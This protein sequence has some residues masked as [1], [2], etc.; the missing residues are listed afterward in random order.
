[1]MGDPITKIVLT[2]SSY[3]AWRMT[4]YS[5]EDTFINFIYPGIKEKRCL[6]SVQTYAC[7][8]DD[9]LGIGSR[10]DL[11]RIPKV[12]ESMGY[13]ISW[14]KYNINK[15]FVSYCQLYGMLPGNALTDER[16]RQGGRFAGL[17][18][19]IHIDT[20]K[21]R[22]CTQFQ[23]MG[24]SENFDKPD[25]LVGKARMLYNDV[26]YMKDTLEL[27]ACCAYDND[28]LQ[29]FFNKLRFFIMEQTNYVRLLMPSWMEWKVFKDP[30]A[31]MPPHFGGL[32]LT[33]PGGLEIRCHAPA[34]ELARKFCFNKENPSWSETVMDWSRGVTVTNVVVNK[35]IADSELR[36]R[37]EAEVLD[38]AG[39]IL[40]RRSFETRDAA[41]IGNRAKWNY[42][43][44]EYT[45]LS[46]EVTLVTSKDN[47]YVTLAIHADKP[48][49][50]RKMRSRQV[51]GSIRKILKNVEVPEDY[52][53]EWKKPKSNARFIKTSILTDAF[54]TNFV[55]P[56]LN[57]SRSMF[58][59]NSRSGPTF[60]QNVEEVR[61]K[62]ELGSF[63]IDLDESRDLSH[64]SSLS[65]AEED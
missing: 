21:L 11:M 54:D 47:V 30:V 17:S 49:V 43:G 19:M 24:G 16:T 59:K 50:V 6:T 4:R 9:H 45:D 18:R 13:E 56:S 15:K 14:D 27:A 55:R 40:S 41:S 28:E 58:Y 20:P 42:I 37:T 22:C 34:F 48:Q 33:V 60:V 35:L 7:A 63:Q 36:V 61:E 46:K 57:I 44:E 51:L 8:G 38:E 62:T 65:N 29:R 12:M 32:G 39:E 5:E 25:P 10:H 31:Y 53:F 23:K 1:M 52:V 64:T 26:I 3:A 2:M